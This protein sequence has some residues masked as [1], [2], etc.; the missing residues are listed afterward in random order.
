MEILLV[1]LFFAAIGLDIAAIY[2]VLEQIN[3]SIFKKFY[4]IIFILIFPIFGAMREL[5]STYQYSDIEKD[6][7][8]TN[9]NDG[10]S[11]I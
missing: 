11:S 1:I 6:S 3:Y 7:S 8:A 9:N 4:K 5:N 10:I 2:S